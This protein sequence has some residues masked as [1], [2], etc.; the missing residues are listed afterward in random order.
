MDMPP[1]DLWGRWLL[2]VLNTITSMFKL[3][4]LVVG[5][6]TVNHNISGVGY[7]TRQGFPE[8]IQARIVRT[9]RM[10]NRAVL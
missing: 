4:L 2:S 9:L 7:V 10:G 5:L 3:Q 6:K 8:L 1:A